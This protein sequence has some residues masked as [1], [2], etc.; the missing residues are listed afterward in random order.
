MTNIS[1]KYTLTK[2]DAIS[3]GKGALIAIAGALLTYLAELIP[4]FDFGEYTPFVVAIA[5][6]LINAIRLFLKKTEYL[7]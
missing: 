2:K 6:I 4:K 7:K 5:A 1:Q 3:I